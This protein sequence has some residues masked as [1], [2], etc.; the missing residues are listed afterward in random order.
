M[1]HAPTI[2][3]FRTVD[4]S[5]R[6]EPGDVIFAEGEAGDRMYVVREGSV[7]LTSNGEPVEDVGPGGVFGE[8]ALIDSSARSA[9]A[10]AST[11][12]DL[13]GLDERTLLF[14]VSQTP[15]FALSVM[16]VLADRLRRATTDRL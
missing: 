9:T 13:V 16:R 10:T 12:C 3:I 8:L 7:A 11:A 6:F 1:V 4:V 2:A 15:F 5:E 14:H